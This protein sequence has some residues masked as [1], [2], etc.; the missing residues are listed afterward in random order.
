[1]LS[2]VGLILERGRKD[3]KIWYNYKQQSSSQNKGQLLLGLEKN[4]VA[5]PFLIMGSNPTTVTEVIIKW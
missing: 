3:Y 1:M 5:D 4:P 2:H